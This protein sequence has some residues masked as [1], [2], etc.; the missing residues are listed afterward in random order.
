MPAG[1]PA[2]SQPSSE[3]NAG[4][5]DMHLALELI[6]DPLTAMARRSSRCAWDRLSLSTESSFCLTRASRA[7]PYGPSPRATISSVILTTLT[8][9]SP[10]RERPRRPESRARRAS[11]VRGAARLHV[12]ARTRSEALSDRTRHAG[13]HSG[14]AYGGAQG[15]VGRRPGANSPAF[16]L[17][18]CRSEAA[19]TFVLLE[20]GELA[21]FSEGQTAMLV[22]YLPAEDVVRVYELVEAGCPPGLAGRIVG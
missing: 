8:I 5:A 17:A 3:R 21:G 4:A 7:R 15:V 13:G 19:T 18:A 22:T 6:G 12:G 2:R 11:S 14:S 16:P 1:C 20:R 10:G 9:A